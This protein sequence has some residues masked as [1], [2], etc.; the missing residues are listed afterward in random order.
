MA[1]I[2]IDIC[3]RMANSLTCS[4]TTTISNMAGVT[5]Y[6][7]T[8]NV[9]A[10]V[11]GVGIQKTGSG[12]TVT[13][14]RVGDR[15]SAKLGRF[16]AGYGFIFGGCLTDGYSAVVASRACSGDIRMIKTAVRCQVQETDGIVAVIAFDDR[17]RMK[18]RFSDGYDTIM[19]FAAISKDFLM[20][21]KRD[22]VKSLWGMTGLAGITGGDVSRRFRKK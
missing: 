4:R 19:T 10:G 14:F 7:R 21:G 2:A 15:V 11:V 17:R 12:M 1:G 9:R 6:T 3:N 22:N 20:I 5:R 8:H 16:A 13:A 18:V